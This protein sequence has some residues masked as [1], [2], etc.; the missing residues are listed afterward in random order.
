MPTL[1]LSTLTG[2]IDKINK[3]YFKYKMDIKPS[4]GEVV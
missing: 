2:C 3:L 4:I 1:V